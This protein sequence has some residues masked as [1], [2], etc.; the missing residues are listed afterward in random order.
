MLTISFILTLTIVY[1]QNR[2]N[3]SLNI[4]EKYLTDWKGRY[5]IEYGLSYSHLWGRHISSSISVNLFGFHKSEL[6]L[7][8]RGYVDGKEYFEANLGIGYYIVPENSSIEIKTEIGLNYRNRT[9][10][11]V[12]GSGIT[13]GGWAEVI[14]DSYTEN[15]I[16]VS[17]SSYINY[18]ISNRI[19]LGFYAQLKFYPK[20]TSFILP[21]G[22]PHD[23][24]NTVSYGLSFGFSF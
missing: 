24:P 16:G 13:S 7:P 17:G 6:Q 19:S 10:V 11:I 12:V 22:I 1:S 4:G 3:V 2:N 14:A 5:G 8:P 15:D 9:E 18:F 23:S 21:E 20:E